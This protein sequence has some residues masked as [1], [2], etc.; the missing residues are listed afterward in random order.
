MQIN[1]LQ[2]KKSS[3]FYDC[4]CSLCSY[5]IENENMNYFFRIQKS[6]FLKC[7]HAK[8]YLKLMLL[9]FKTALMTTKNDKNAIT[10]LPMLSPKHH[11][12]VGMFEWIDTTKCFLFLIDVQWVTKNT[13]LAVFETCVFAYISGTTCVKKS[14]LHLFA[15]S[16]KEL[17][18]E[19]LIFHIL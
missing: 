13:H 10:F 14:Y 18:N 3:C 4:R 9:G 17:S 6:W 15:S 2:A 11:F 16:S 8:I 5:F 1:L 19:E 12:L 7:L